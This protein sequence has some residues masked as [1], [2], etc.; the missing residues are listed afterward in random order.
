M[1]RQLDSNIWVVERPLRFLGA[2]LGTR[3]TVIKLM[4]GAC[5]CIL[6]FGSI[7]KRSMA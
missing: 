7:P 6:R 4:T 2:E 5:S 1:I 3:M